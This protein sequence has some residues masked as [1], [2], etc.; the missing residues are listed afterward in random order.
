[1]KQIALGMACASALAWCSPARSDEPAQDA[2]K[3]FESLD[4]NGDGILSS[5]EIGDDR[6]RFFDRLVRIG[7][8]NDDR[9]LTRDEF[10][11]AMSQEERPVETPRSRFG[12]GDRPMP[13][14]GQMFDRLD[15]N[16][17]GK[18]SKSEIPE[19]A[20]AEF[21]ERL[22]RLF[23][24]AQKSELTREE[25]E[26]VMASYGP[27]DARRPE[28]G[29]SEAARPEASR[30]GGRGEGGRPPFGR[31][32]RDS[33]RPGPDGE[34]GRDGDR[35]REMGR[36]GDRRPGPEREGERPRG[37][38]ADRMERSERPDG[39]EG[40][41][42]FGGMSR[43]SG[44]SGNA[45]IRVLDRNGDGRLNRDEVARIVDRFDELDRNGDGE[46]EVIELIGSFG[47][48]SPFGGRPGFGGPDGFRRDGGDREREMARDSDRRPEGARDGERPRPEGDRRPEGPRDG[49][50]PRPEGRPD[51]RPDM[52]PEGGPPRGERGPGGPRGLEGRGADGRGGDFFARLDKDGDGFISRDEA[53]ERI[54]DRFRDMD[55]NGD[56]KISAE[57]L[58]DAISREF[59]VPGERR[60]RRPEL[61]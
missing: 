51:A 1:M 5:D 55:A 39:R 47:G 24:A 41:R 18:F 33:E 61:E 50:R 23:T 34:R 20:P 30:E 29:R 53:P 7:D 36:E 42:G 48:F 44:R 4:K 10:V 56:G 54:R 32:G 14:P 28:P 43:D 15:R 3:L 35:G 58:R 38:E 40:F 27:A 9:Q 46:L 2:A 52:R 31:P 21:R 13:S 60:E 49:E 6:R 59:G 17:D 8:K 12:G 22:E 25:Y 37:P 19:Q 16:R 57:E 26:K 45:L 11:A